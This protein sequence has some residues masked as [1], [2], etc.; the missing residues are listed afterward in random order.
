MHAPPVPYGPRAYRRR[1]RTLGPAVAL[2][3]P[4]VV[5]VVGWL[6]LR[7]S[8]GPGRGVSGFVA[9][10]L[11]LPALTAVGV[12]LAA[13]VNYTI[14][15]LLSALVWLIVGTIAAR[16]ATRRPAPMWRDFWREFAWIAAGLCIGA[17]VAVVAANLILGRTLG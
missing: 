16:R 1:I 13:D 15:V 5:A 8:N 12:P 10:V 3:A 9:C 7:G 11:A 2:V 14:P 6:L 4:A 17:V